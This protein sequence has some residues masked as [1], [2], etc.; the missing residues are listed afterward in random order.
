MGQL[1]S[2]IEFEASV[3]PIQEFSQSPDQ[4]V[5]RRRVPP[6]RLGLT[7]CQRNVLVAFCHAETIDEVGRA[8]QM[9]PRRVQFTIESVGQLLGVRTIHRMLAICIARQWITPHL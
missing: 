3:Y 2:P 4:S 5:S 8:L 9:D 6:E 1:V 7:Q